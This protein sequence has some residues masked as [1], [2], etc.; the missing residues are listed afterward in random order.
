MIV[1][2]RSMELSEDEAQL[3]MESEDE[4]SELSDGELQD[5]FAKGLL[6]PGMNVRVDKSKKCVNNVDAMKEC[7][8]DFRK[9]LPWVERLDMTNLPAEDVL[10]KLEGQVL[11]ESNGDTT[12]DD[13]F[14]REMFF[15][16]QAQA[17]V[18]QALPLLNKHGISTKRPDDYF[19][20]MAKSD[21]H[22]QKIRKKLISKQMILERSE[23]A[24]K[25]RE[26]RKFGKKVQIQV[27][28]KR[29]KEKKAMMN[30][31][32]KYQKG[33]T[34]KLDF[35]EGD[36]KEKNA[37]QQSS[38]KPLN[39][40][41]SSSGKRKYKDQKFGY[42]GKKSGMKWNTKD[43]YND[44]S[45]FRAKVAHSKGNKGGKK[46]KGGKQNKRPGKS[47]RRKMKARS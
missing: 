14:Q 29:Q 5:A 30:A 10:S 20:E 9:D 28:Q 13:D 41:G 21:Q 26:Q 17:T 43:S 18:L 25:L 22:M 42:G 36:K 47:V 8:A 4:N 6:K 31:V 3:G 1:E 45:S 32:K 12:V 33:M 24:K 15:Y 7:L 35:L 37:P 19:A 11:G 46:G 40:K 34:D 39:K 44:V 27:M 16:R 23:K 38:K 2:S